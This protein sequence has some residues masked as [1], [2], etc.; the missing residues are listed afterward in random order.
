MGAEAK[1]EWRRMMTVLVPLGLYTPADRAVLA[2]YCES[3]SLYI[4]AMQ[5][6]RRFGTVVKSPNGMP[7]ASPYWT[8]ARQAEESMRAAAREFG[9]TPSSRTRVSA[10]APAAEDAFEELLRGSR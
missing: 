10:G 8:Q 1:R 4:E 5:A 2:G 9:L 7:M 6:L 3:W